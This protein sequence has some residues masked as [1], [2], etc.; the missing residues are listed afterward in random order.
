MITDISNSENK[1]RGIMGFKYV[2]SADRS[3]LSNYRGN[4]LYGF[5]SCGPAKVSPEPVYS[6]VCPTKDTYDRVTGVLRLPPV[7]LRRVEGALEEVLG[8]GSVVAQHPFE[9]ERVIDED[10]RVVGLTEMSP[11]GIGTVDTAISWRADN[12][13]R[14]WFTALTRKL[15][16]LKKLFNFKVVVGGPGSWQLLSPFTDYLRQQ[17]TPIAAQASRFKT[18]VNDTFTRL[19]ASIDPWVKQE[20]GVDYVVEGEADV[21]APSIFSSIENGNAPEVIHCLTNSIRDFEDIPEIKRATL[22]GSVEIMRGCGR[23]C[24]F[25]APNLRTKRDFP[26]ERVVKE[27][28][29]NIGMGHRDVW[30]LSEELTLYGCDNKDKFPNQDAIIGLF[31]ALKKAGAGR[32]GCTHWTFAG[33]R[34]APDLIHKL[35]EINCLQ[36]DWMGVQPGLEWISPRMVKKF[37][38]YKVKPFSPEECP[39]TVREAIK[40]MNRNHYYPAITLVVGHPEEQ[41]DEVD[42]T[43]EFVEHLSKVDGMRGIVAPLL[44]VDYYRPHRTMDYDKMNEHHWRLYYT[45]WKHN[46]R[47]FGDTVWL[48]T[49]N[50]DFLSRLV[51]IFGVHVLDHYILRFLKTEFKRR[52]HYV[53]DWMAT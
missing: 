1:K 46:A 16:E 27:A 8:S 23:G 49:Q 7:G 37:M 4:F 29:I 42:M 32:I 15:K 18:E 33:V 13:N 24:D 2:L 19:K 28:S 35:S 44:Y 22:T 51:T 38:P 43:T 30:L 39:E 11:L 31:K 53:P 34:A 48:A 6:M 5:L 14:K 12:W 17:G 26:I 20:L 41:D 52:F 25:C 21:L 47:E 50:F 40:I 45:A 9:I 3:Q 36:R 10:T